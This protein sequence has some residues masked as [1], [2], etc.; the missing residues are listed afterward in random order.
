MSQA[1]PEDLRFDFSYAPG[2]NGEG[3]GQEVQLPFRLLVLG[4]FMPNQSAEDYLQAKPVQVGLRN[5]DRILS[6]Q[7]IRLELSMAELCPSDVAMAWFGGAQS[8]IQLKLHSLQDFN[9]EMIAQREPTLARIQSILVH[10]QTLKRDQRDSKLINLSE[11]NSIDRKL[12]GL[13]TEDM[14]ISRDVLDFLLT[15]LAAS[16]NELLNR[17]IHSPSLQKLEAAW[18]GL[19]LLTLTAADHPS[20][21][22]CFLPAAM[23]WLRDDLERAP[24]LTETHLF[25]VLYANEYGQFGGKPYGAVITDYCFELND[26]D[27]ILLRQLAQLGSAAHAPIIAQAAPSFFGVSEYGELAN[28]ASLKGVQSGER[29]IKWRKLQ[30][31]PEAMYL[32]LTLPRLLMRSLYSVGEGGVNASIYEED[33]GL[34]ESP[35]LWGSAAYA[36]GTCLLRS[37]QRFGICTDITGESGGEVCGLSHLHLKNTSDKLLPIEVLLSENKEAELIGLGFTPVS[38]AKANDKV[39]FYAAN[40]V[41]WGCLQHDPKDTMENLGAQLPYLFVILRIA[42]YLKMIC[43]DMIGSVASVTDLEAQLQRWLKRYVS[44]VESPSL[45]VR[46]RRP[47]K[48]VSLVVRPDPN[49]PDWLSVDLAITPHLRYMDQ[50]FSLNLNLNVNSQR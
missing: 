50:D 21:Q 33:I 6:A 48:K 47:L 26:S 22:V 41:Y 5:F 38:V 49:R 46:S 42:H 12:I 1:S 37:F 17:I 19:H 29:F 14:Q 36:L 16:L 11:L 3:D 10:G 4:E 27:L 2:A 9:P 24:R 15:D 34:A 13:T 39:L 30:S 28:L 20:C 40:S 45:A 25:D 43:R 44:D 7:N 8:S 23:E 31:S 32:V 35:Y 18:R